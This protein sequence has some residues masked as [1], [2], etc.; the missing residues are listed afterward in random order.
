M[1]RKSDEPETARGPGSAGGVPAPRPANP[2]RRFTDEEVGKILRNAA[3]LQE[4][5]AAAPGGGSAHGLTLED[6][7]QVAAEAGIDPRFVEV[8]AADLATPLAREVSTLAGGSYAWSAHRTVPG[9]V[10]EE[11]RDRVV[12]AV[13]GIMGQK[14]VVEDLY[15]RLEWSYDDGLGPVMVG[16]ASRDGVTE[17]DVSARRGG[18]VGLTLGLGV[19]FGGMAVGGLITALLGVSGPAAVFPAII[20]GGALSWAGLAAGWRVAAGRWEERVERLADAV[21]GASAEVAV[22]EDEDGSEEERE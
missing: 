22:L 19:P 1:R 5:S 11:D 14:G 15:G 21:A 6:L 18:A 13:R 7:R 3:D 20:A 2:V 4:R 10:R 9:H 16:V 12:R 8:A 17:V